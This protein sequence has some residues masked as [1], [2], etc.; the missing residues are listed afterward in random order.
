MSMASLFLP[1]I[2]IHFKIS[3][4]SYNHLISPQNNNV[5]QNDPVTGWFTVTGW[6][7]QTVS[8]CDL[9]VLAFI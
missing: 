1:K 2:L 9:L 3:N 6:Y 4:K 7:G 5:I 8:L